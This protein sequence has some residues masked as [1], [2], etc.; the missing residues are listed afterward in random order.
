MEIKP[1]L[2]RLSERTVEMLREQSGNQRRSMASLADEILYA[3][4]RRRKDELSRLDKM[5]QAA[6]RVT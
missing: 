3:E 1:T 2:L 6:G 5:V 4:L